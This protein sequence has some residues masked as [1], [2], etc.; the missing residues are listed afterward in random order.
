[1]NVLTLNAGSS[2][3]KYALYQQDPALRRVLSG[4]MDRIGKIYARRSRP[5][6]RGILTP[7]SRHTWR[8]LKA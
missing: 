6:V 7:A 5:C 2:S 8:A 1:M 4:Q 3:I